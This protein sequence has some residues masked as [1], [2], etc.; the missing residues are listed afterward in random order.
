MTA[1]LTLNTRSH[2]MLEVIKEKF[3][4]NPEQMRKEIEVL[5]G[6]LISILRDKNIDYSSLRP[7]LTPS[8]D[9]HEAAFLFDSHA[10]NSNLYG[11]ETFN[12]LLPLFDPRSTHSILHGD[13][14]GN[15]QQLIFEILQESVRWVRS[16]TFRHS[17][18]MYCVYVN[19]LTEPQ[20]ERIRAGLYSCSA[21]LGYVD[22]TF[23]SRAK[24]FL[25]TT[26]SSFIVKKGQTLIIGHED[27]RSNDENINITYYP[28]EDFGHK[29]VSLQGRYFSIFLAYKIERP[30]FNEFETDTELSLNAISNDVVLFDGFDVVLDENKYQYLLNNKHG[31][32]QQAGLTGDFTREMITALIKAKLNANYIYNLEYRGA[33]D[34]MKFNLQIQIPR[35]FG[36]PARLTVALEYIPKERVLRVITLF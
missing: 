26:L 18:L 25:S 29:L 13:L 15:D 14:I 1:I 4:L 6:D 10:F 32:L 3:G 7:A 31:K 21:Y 28:L 5:H 9:R 35:P 22:M 2:F 11:R 33:H 27:D 34:V 36:Y 17:T 23:E 12:C 16:Y 24:L 20:L 19:H 8:I 30:V